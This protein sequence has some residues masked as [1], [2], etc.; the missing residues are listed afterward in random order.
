VIVGVR[1]ADLSNAGAQQD[2]N[3]LSGISDMIE[4][5]GDQ[6]LVSFPLGDARISVF[7]PSRQRPKEGEPLALKVNEGAMH[8][9]DAASGLS[10]LRPE[11]T[12]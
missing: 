7:V 9:F 12:A 10:L 3:V 8:L 6:V 5:H 2:S 4:F 11:I 1:P